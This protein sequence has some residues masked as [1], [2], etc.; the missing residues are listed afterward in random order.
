MWD[1][2]ESDVSVMSFLKQVNGLKT[3]KGPNLRSLHSGVLRRLT[4][5]I[6]LK[7]KVRTVCS[8]RPKQNVGGRGFK[9]LNC[10][11]LVVFTETG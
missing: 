4:E 3:V 9:R 10:N 8:S 1:V 2:N 7:L 5:L 6:W 11:F